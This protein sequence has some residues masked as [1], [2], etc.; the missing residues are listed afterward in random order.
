M[1]EY[2]DIAANGISTA[3]TTIAIFITIATYVSISTNTAIETI[4]KNNKKSQ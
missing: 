4:T 3:I 1:A 2:E